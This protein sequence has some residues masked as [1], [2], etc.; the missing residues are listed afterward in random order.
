MDA[1]IKT[2]LEAINQRLDKTDAAMTAFMEAQNR[3]TAEIQADTIHR[4]IVTESQLPPA[5][6]P[7]LKK[8]FA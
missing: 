2:L 4:A 8:S 3:A 7:R 1:E 5:I 6:K